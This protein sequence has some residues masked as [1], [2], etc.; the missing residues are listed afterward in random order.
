MISTLKKYWIS[1]LKEPR[2][3]V[4]EALIE[5]T[6]GTTIL[7]IILFGA[8]LFI[9]AAVSRDLGDTTPTL[10]IL[11]LSLI[12]GPIIGAITWGLLFCLTYVGSRLFQGYATLE[13]TR[14]AISWATIA[15]STKLVIYIPSLLIFR[16]EMFSS[17][18]PIIQSSG[19]VT[20]L[21]L[22]F[23]L[24]DIAFTIYFFIVASKVVAEMNRFSPWK[25]FGS[26]FLIIG[27]TLF[28]LLS[29]GYVINL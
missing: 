4:H 3:T 11:L 17:E 29:I 1:M 5:G 28:L 15:Y 13:E 27:A 22:L 20:F 25:G 6:K 21:F 16:G 23:L 14:K 19:F 12:L 7:L 10:V 9:S 18:Q 24:L 26:I 2:N 8:T